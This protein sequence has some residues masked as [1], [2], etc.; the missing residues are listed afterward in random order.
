MRERT[1]AMTPEEERIYEA[2]MNKIVEETIRRSLKR[3]LPERA[4]RKRE[5]YRRDLLTLPRRFT[6]RENDA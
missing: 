6:S 1:I 5:I 2:G 4:S 3:T